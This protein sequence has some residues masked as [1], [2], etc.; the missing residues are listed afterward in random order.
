MT[1]S[2]IKSLDL[3][4]RY[5]QFLDRDYLARSLSALY[6]AARSKKS[7]NEILAVALAMRVVS[8][9]EFITG[10]EFITG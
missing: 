10:Y 9:D 5:A 7:Q 6:R 4:L 8:H 2:E 1:K 3:I